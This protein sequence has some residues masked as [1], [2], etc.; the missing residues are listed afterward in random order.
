MFEV[1]VAAGVSSC[2]TLG[3][4]RMGGQP[5]KAVSAV[6]SGPSRVVAGVEVSNRFGTGVIGA[7]LFGGVILSR[8]LE[9]CC[10]IRCAAVR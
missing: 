4:R 3:V 9:A 8:S 2:E 1:A 7:E 6:G 10:V 5:R